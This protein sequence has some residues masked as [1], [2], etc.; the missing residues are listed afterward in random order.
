MA[1]YNFFLKS[2]HYCKEINNTYLHFT[3]HSTS[4]KSIPNYTIITR[5]KF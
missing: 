4:V 2:K 3:R 1:V 5:Q